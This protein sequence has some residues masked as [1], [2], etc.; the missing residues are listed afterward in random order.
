MSNIRTISAVALCAAA[1]AACQAKN[2]QPAADDRICT[3]FPGANGAPAV[4]PA[5]PT[6]ALDDCLHRWGYALALGRDTADVVAQATVAACSPA[7]SRWNQQALASG[8]D[9]GTTAGQTE[10]APSLVTGEPTTPLAQHYT[11]AAGRALFYVAQARAGK[12][13]APAAVTPTASGG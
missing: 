13:A 5:D 2:G 11:F 12:C 4:N 7:L 6:S 9:A 10:S 8:A 1:L 3:P